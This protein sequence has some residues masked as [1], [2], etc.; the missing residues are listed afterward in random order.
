MKQECSLER[1]LATA[2][3][4]LVYLDVLQSHLGQPGAGAGAW[5]PTALL[6]GVNCLLVEDI[7]PLRG[8][9]TERYTLEISRYSDLS[10]CN[11]KTTRL[12][13]CCYDKSAIWTEIFY[14]Q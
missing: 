14:N 10:S 5:S 1:L 12:P 4:R 3:H 13:V 6:P 7:P 11:N 8:L 9:E 2:A